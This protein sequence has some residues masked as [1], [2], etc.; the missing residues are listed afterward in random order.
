[1]HLMYAILPIAFLVVPV[2]AQGDYWANLQKDD[3]KQLEFSE[4]NRLGLP[5]GRKVRLFSGG[6]SEDAEKIG[7]TRESIETTVRS[8]L[9][10][11]RIYNE[12][13]GSE[14]AFL[15]VHVDVFSNAFNIRLEFNKFVS[16]MPIMN[17]L[18]TIVHP[19]GRSTVST[20]DTG[21]MGTHGNNP[22]FILQTLG[23]YTDIF[24]D[25]YL[26]VNE[27]VCELSK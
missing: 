5:C 24:I 14:L 13:L 17:H 25:E 20:W 8:R 22:Q 15:F 2:I 6:L 10:G 23:Q 19:G 4:I 9:R 26:H 12:E 27:K 1:M 11:A 7:L 21:G 18:G 16:F 3:A